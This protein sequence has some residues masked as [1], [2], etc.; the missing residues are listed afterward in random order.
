MV[1]TGST[2]GGRSTDGDP[3]RGS[4]SIAAFVELH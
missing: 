4:A 2:D 3:E 1:S